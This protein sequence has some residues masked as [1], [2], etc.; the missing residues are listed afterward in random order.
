M[1]QAIE[2]TNDASVSDQTAQSPIQLPEAIRRDRVV[3]VGDADLKR[4]LEQLFENA[5][6]NA[7]R[8]L[9]AL[10]AAVQNSGKCSRP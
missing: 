5:I 4:R 8:Q 2:S 10:D 1:A 7:R 6:I 3:E 9:M